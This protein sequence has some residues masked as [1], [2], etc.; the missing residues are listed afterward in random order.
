MPD[1][2]VHN[3]WTEPH[4][5]RCLTPTLR[6]EFVLGKLMQR[7]PKRFRKL[8][9]ETCGIEMPRPVQLTSSQWQTLLATMG[10]ASWRSLRC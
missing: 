1:L 4:F 2:G 10:R 8:L 6:G 7:D 3:W 9:L 5:K